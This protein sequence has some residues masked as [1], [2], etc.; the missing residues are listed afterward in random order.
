MKNL[1]VLSLLV[2]AALLLLGTGCSSLKKSSGVDGYVINYKLPVGQVFNFVSN[3]EST[4]ESDQMGQLVVVDLNSSNDFEYE[5]T[6]MEENGAMAMKLVIKD[7]TQEAKTAMGENSTDYSSWIGK[8]MEFKVSPQGQIADFTGIDQIETL[9][10]A[11]GEQVGPEQIE[12]G[13]EG[14]FPPMPENPVKKGDVWER[15]STDTIPYGG[16]SLIVETTTVYSVGDEVTYEG[17][18]SLQILANTSQSMAGSF[19]QNGMDITLKRDSRSE[20][21]IHWSLDRGM[22]RISETTTKA[23]GVAEVTSMGVTIP[24]KIESK[25]VSKVVFK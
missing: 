22:Y 5:V 14:V 21:V 2:P 3:S 15:S 16:S 11:L 1:R 8:T 24:Q 12:G 20:T 17:E 18:K 23:S 10:N 4:I 6:G 19:E 25:T 13:T 9:A 7:I